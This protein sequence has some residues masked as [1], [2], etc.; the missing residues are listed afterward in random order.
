MSK[1]FIIDGTSYPVHLIDVKRKADILD[2]KAYRTEDGIV[3][4]KVIGTYMD[5]SVTVGIEDDLDLYDTLFNVLCAP[6]ES[7]MIQLP[8][9][10]SAQQRYT[11]SVADGILR[12]ED[13]GT[14]YKDLSFNITCTAPTRTA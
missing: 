10:S 3:H 2:A 13:D 14:L 4:R 8:N 11:S 5:Y 6:V 7:H 1:L 9:E 12:V